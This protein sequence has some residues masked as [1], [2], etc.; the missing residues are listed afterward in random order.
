MEK[1]LLQLD[2][3]ALPIREVEASQ[4]F[5]SEVLGLPLVEALSGDDWEGCPG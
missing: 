5:Y 1:A 2:H 4:R 3:V